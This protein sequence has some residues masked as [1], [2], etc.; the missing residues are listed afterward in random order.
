MLWW[1]NISDSQRVGICISSLGYRC[2]N[3]GRRQSRASFVGLMDL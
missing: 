3:D 2:G 1:V